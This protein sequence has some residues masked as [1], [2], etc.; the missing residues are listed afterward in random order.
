MDYTIE[1]RNLK[2]ARIN[3]SEFSQVKLIVPYHFSD[4]EITSLLEMKKDWIKSKLQYFQNTTELVYEINSDHIL[5]KGEI[6][7][8]PNGDILKWY[9]IEAAVYIKEK[10][11]FLASI[12]NTPLKNIYIRDTKHKWGSCSKDL[13]V[14]FN[15]RLILM[16]AE[17]IDYVIVHELCHIKVLKHTNAFW[18]RVKSICP[19]YI[20]NSEWLQKNGKS[21]YELANKLSKP[22]TT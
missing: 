19:N 18:L 3:V 14:S 9:K 2:H 15:W 20:E 5:F 16:P 7:E 11:K 10:V 13:N 4:L 22:E 12:Y 1:R 21:I 17:I 6:I 8:K